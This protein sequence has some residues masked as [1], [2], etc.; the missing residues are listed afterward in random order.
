MND[1]PEKL[2]FSIDDI[3]RQWIEAGIM[4]AEPAPEPIPLTQSEEEARVRQLVRTQRM[5]AFKSNCPDEFMHKIDRTLLP[6]LEAWDKADA[7]AGTF[8]GIWLWSHCTGKGK[9]RMLYR[10]FGR[11]H[12]EQGKAVIKISGQALAEEYFAY[13]MK[14]E[15]RSFYSWMNRY[16]VVM[17]DD[18]DKIDLEDR[19][20]PR[21]CRELFDEFYSKHK[22]VLVTAN[23]PIEHFQKRI[24]DS[25]SRRMHAVCEEISF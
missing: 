23:E 14:G 20:A 13:H 5:D 19:R 8:P 6:N 22:S 12:V 17:I 2:S 11:L 15:P 7:W 25:T 24:G 9:T 16:D 1:E 3:R 21:M 10:Q 4:P 18:I